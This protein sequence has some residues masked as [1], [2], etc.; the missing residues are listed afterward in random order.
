MELDDIPIRS[1]PL[2]SAVAPSNRPAMVKQTIAAVARQSYRPI[3]L[4]LVAH[5]YS[6]DEGE[7]RDYA[8][9]LGLEGVSTLEV[10]AGVPLGEVLNRAFAVANG[11]YIWKADD[12][13]YYGPKF[14]HDLLDA[15]LYTDAEVVGKA[16]HYAFIE[17]QNMT[18][19]RTAPRSTAM[20]HMCMA[21]P[22][23]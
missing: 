18:V 22:W 16:A 12:D 20:F 4:V 7:L 21:P 6:P 19:I 5:G 1:S 2:V 8:K 14:L 23:S 11:K 3:E 17:G 15:F 9:S 10:D 13:D